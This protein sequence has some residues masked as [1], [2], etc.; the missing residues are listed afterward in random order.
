MSKRTKYKYYAYVIIDPRNNTPIYVGKGCRGRM[1][2]HKRNAVNPE[3]KHRAVHRK[4]QEII[5]L[6]LKLKY[7]KIMCPTEQDAFDKE[8]ELIAEYGRLDEST[9]TLCNHSDGGDGGR[10]WTKEQKAQRKKRR[11]RKKQ[12]KL[13]T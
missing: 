11:K 6:G 12:R 2:H 5:N 9:G 3:F 7:Q 4:I 10:G 13:L 1:Y 8:I